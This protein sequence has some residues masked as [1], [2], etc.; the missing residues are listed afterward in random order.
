M[1]REQIVKVADSEIHGRGLFVAAPV[2]PGTTLDEGH[3]LIVP[4]TEDAHHCGIADL[5]SF[6]CGPAN[7]CIALGVTSLCNHGD[8]PNAEVIIDPST[9]T[10]VLYAL[11][12]LSSGEEVLIDYGVEYW[13]AIA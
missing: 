8:Y 5:Y 3:L 1:A 4:T 11:T 12:R 9:M 7:R 10:Y 13:E 6:E 2:L